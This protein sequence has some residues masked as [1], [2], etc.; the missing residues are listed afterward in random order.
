MNKSG[1]YISQNQIQTRRMPRQGFVERYLGMPKPSSGR[2]EMA[3]CSVL[4]GTCRPLAG[5]AAGG[6]LA[7]T[8]AGLAQPRPPV[9]FDQALER[10]ELSAWGLGVLGDFS[11]MMI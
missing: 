10:I 11:T 6:A 9:G 2:G 4:S 3:C 1:A 7:G 8:V 5:A